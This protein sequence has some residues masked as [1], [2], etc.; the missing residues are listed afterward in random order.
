MVTLA[1]LMGSCEEVVCLGF[2]VVELVFLLFVP[3][4]EHKKTL[5]YK[6]DQRDTTLPKT[7]FRHCVFVVDPIK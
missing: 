5:K 6:H 3:L 2:T 4:I 7:F 1:L